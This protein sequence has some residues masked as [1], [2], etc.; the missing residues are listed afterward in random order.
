MYFIMALPNTMVKCSIHSCPIS[1]N[2]MIKLQVNDKMQQDMLLLQ[3]F[4]KSHYNLFGEFDLGDVT[5]LMNYFSKV[6]QGEQA[7]LDSMFWVRSTCKTLLCRLVRYTS[8]FPERVERQQ[9]MLIVPVLLDLIRNSEEISQDIRQMGYVSEVKESFR[10]YGKISPHCN[11]GSCLS[12][13]KYSGITLSTWEDYR[14]SW[15]VQ[16]VE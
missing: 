12:L 11:C 2:R 14:D 8:H 3:R 15:S 4:Y 5:H 7:I 16:E 9:F 13:F 1:L 6:R 10:N